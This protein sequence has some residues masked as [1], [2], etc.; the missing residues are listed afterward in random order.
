LQN[1]WVWC[2]DLDVLEVLLAASDL[3]VVSLLWIEHHSSF[4]D[5]VEGKIILGDFPLDWLNFL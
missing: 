1:G 3:F 4:L 5:L 2:H